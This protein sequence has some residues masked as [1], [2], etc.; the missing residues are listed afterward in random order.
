MDKID[1][2]K[3]FVQYPHSPALFSKF[4]IMKPGSGCH[5]V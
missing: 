3:Q 1:E 5:G 2:W 4:D